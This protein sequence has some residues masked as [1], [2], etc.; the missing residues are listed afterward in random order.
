MNVFIGVGKICD[1]NINGK[2]LR[3]NLAVK[4][5]KPCSVPCVLFDPDDDAKKSMEQFEKSNRLVW[6][7]GR[8][9]S[10]EYDFQGRTVRKFE[11]VAYANS[12]KPV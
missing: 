4:Q 9:M 7:H 12:I 3:F 8:A 1:V 11:I 10:Y 5:E 2:R 6:L